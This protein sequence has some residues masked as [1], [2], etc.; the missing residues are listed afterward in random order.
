MS[1]VMSLADTS[2]QVLNVWEKRPLVRS[3]S[4]AWVH[5]LSSY[6]VLLFIS[7]H[8]S[9]LV[10]LSFFSYILTTFSVDLDIYIW[11]QTASILR[12]F[13]SVTL[14]KPTTLMYIE[15]NALA[16]STYERL[17]SIGTRVVFCHHVVWIGWGSNR[18]MV[19][20]L[21]AGVLTPTLA[22]KWLQKENVS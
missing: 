16:L 19:S 1:L 8:L 21:K 2:G 7:S 11:K 4:M 6:L 14:D 20:V 22:T 9:L 3:S 13:W 12:H 15:A 10:L 5:A 17:A 18:M